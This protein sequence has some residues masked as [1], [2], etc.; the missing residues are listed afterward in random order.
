MLVFLSVFILYLV[1]LCPIIYVGDSPLFASASFSLGT[2][3]PPGYP[4]YI[5]LG[6]LGTLLPLGNIA[7]KVNLVNATFGGLSAFM[8]YKVVYYLTDNKYAAWSSALFLSVV[9]VFWTGSI[10]A[11]GV[12]SLNTFLCLII[13]LLI[14]RMLRSDGSLFRQLMLVA[15]LL[16]LGMGNHQT[17]GL[18]GLSAV[19]LF[20][21]KWRKI[22]MRWV[23]FAVFFLLAGISVNFLIY[24]RS[25][26]AVTSGIDIL[27]SY[28]GTLKALENVFL[29]KAYNINTVVSLKRGTAHVIPHFFAVTVN[30]LKNIVV[31]N[32]KY[33]IPFIVLGLVSSLRNMRFLVYIGF[34][35]FLWV[36]FLGSVTAG[37]HLTEEGI[38]IVSVYYAPLYAFMSVLMGLGVAIALEKAAAIWKG[39]GFVPRFLAY[40]AVAFPLCLA[41]QAYALAAPV[42]YPL[43][44]TWARDMLVTLPVGSMLLNYNDNPTFTS[45]YMLSVEKFRDDVLQMD[46]GGKKDNYGLETAPVWKYNVLYPDFYRAENV[47]VSYLDREFAAKGK[48]FTSNPKDMTPVLKKHYSFRVMGLTSEL[49]PKGAV[50]GRDVIDSESLKANKFLN[51][52]AIRELPYMDDFLAVELVN[53]YALCLLIYGDA[54]SESGDLQAGRKAILESISLGDPKIYLGPYIKYLMDEGRVG[55]GLAFLRKLER[56][57]D[58]RQRAVANILEYKVLSV[59]GDKE[60]AQ[61]KYDFIKDSG[62]ATL[63]NASF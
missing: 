42:Q 1:T 54:M 23:P 26:V 14:V 63:L 59:T 60:E 52:E 41:P 17:I 28:G 31:P 8:T 35:L 10:N 33:G 61:R 58:D 15:F 5:L 43:A 56:K 44:Y 48:L 13:F 20:L 27:Y 12:Y 7:F 25:R 51:Y 18:M 32:V 6:K 22:R 16:G 46:A 21:I 40:S 37:T 3:H 47:K 9:P 39:S 50:P 19:P 29:R 49:F 2:A 4:F 57:G 11:K 38:Q 30:V 53:H 24:V 34:L 62:I 45:F 55:E 36:A